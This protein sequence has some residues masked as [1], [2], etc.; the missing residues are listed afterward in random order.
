MEK[1]VVKY[2]CQWSFRIIGTETEL[3]RCAV[4]DYMKEASF[5]LSASN[6]SSSGKYVS[7]N[8]ETIVLDEK[9]RNKIYI[10]LKNM[11]CVKMV[12]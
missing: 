4:E 8:L 11:A 7:L 1:Q 2:P 12:L 9:S 3:I 10:D 5:K 6:K